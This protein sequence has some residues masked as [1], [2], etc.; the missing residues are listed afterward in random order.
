MKE[1]E[2]FCASC[3]TAKKG[4]PA[5][6]ETAA[7]A[8]EGAAM[9]K[10][11]LIVV[12][13]ACAI[14]VIFFFFSYFAISFAGSSSSVSGIKA[15]FSGGIGDTKGSARPSLLLVWLLAIAMLVAIYVP[16]IRG[17]LESVKLPVIN[18]P[19]IGDLSLYAY[20]AIIVGFIGLIV[21][22]AAYASVIGY[23][24]REL[25]GYEALL[26]MLGSAR[27]YRLGS[28]IGFKMTV[29]AQ[30]VLLG[31]PFADKYFLSKRR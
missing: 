22:I 21:L 14:T 13:A 2:K 6:S 18:I 9:G 17:K 19:V 15:A 10:I 11:A 8:A 5:K 12:S 3:G 28:G 16:K 1:D 20:L 29:F 4:A 27:I 30:L 31:I 24:K 23:V 7:T 25:A 26:S